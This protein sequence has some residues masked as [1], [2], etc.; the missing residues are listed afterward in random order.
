MPFKRKNLFGEIRVAEEW[1]S[2]PRNFSL[3]RK[4]PK[5][6]K[7]PATSACWQRWHLYGRRTAIVPAESSRRELM[8]RYVATLLSAPFVSSAA[9]LRAKLPAATPLLPSRKENL[10]RPS[11]GAAGS[12]TG[13]SFYV[14]FGPIT[15]CSRNSLRLGRRKS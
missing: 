5:I 12:R 8:V 11:G 4:P 9:T 13:S 3:S 6:Y 10:G 2:R 1:L 14:P 7:K 15:C